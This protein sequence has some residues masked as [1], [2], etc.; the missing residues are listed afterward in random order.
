[1][2]ILRNYEIEI[3]PVSYYDAVKRALDEERAKAEAEKQAAEAAAA[4]AA[5]SRKA[6]EDEARERELRITRAREAARTHVGRL[7]GIVTPGD[8]DMLVA[9]AEAEAQGCRIL[10]D[11]ALVRAR[12]ARQ[13]RALLHSSGTPGPLGRAVQGRARLHGPL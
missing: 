6:A 11:G 1:M 4:L 10:K 7:F 5:S 2:G 8:T 13:A 9:K 12:F 3:Q